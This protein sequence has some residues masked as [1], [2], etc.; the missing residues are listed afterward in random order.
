MQEICIQEKELHHTLTNEKLLEIIKE[1]GLGFSLCYGVNPEQ[2]ECKYIRQR[3]RQCKHQINELLQ[4]IIK[5]KKIGAK[6][7]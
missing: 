1:D 3:W 7:D 2:I 5:E 6:N 4:E